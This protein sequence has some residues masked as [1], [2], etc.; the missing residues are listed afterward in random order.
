MSRIDVYK[1]RTD[2]AITNQSAED[3]IQP[4]AVGNKLK[5]LADIV[6]LQTLSVWSS[7]A[8][9]NNGYSTDILV[10]YQNKIYQSLVDSN[11]IVPGTDETKWSLVLDPTPVP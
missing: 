3:S 8:Y 5:E 10:I 1:Q 9:D 11:K 6:Q 2:E 4:L 7:T